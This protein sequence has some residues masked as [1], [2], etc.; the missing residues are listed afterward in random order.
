MGDMNG[1]NL[2]TLKLLINNLN[3]I[4]ASQGKKL[5][6]CAFG[7]LIFFYY[8]KVRICIFD[9]KYIKIFIQKHIKL[10]K[11]RHITTKS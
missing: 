2:R 6:K 9:N 11:I 4:L 8:T 3:K 10:D 7:L 5:F 1:G